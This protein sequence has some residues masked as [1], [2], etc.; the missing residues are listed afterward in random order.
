MDTAYHL[1]GDNMKIKELLSTEKKWTKGTYA[2]NAV[3]KACSPY[4]EEA[5]CF[6]LLGAVDKCYGT[7]TLYPST[8]DQVLS[9]LRNHIGNIAAFNDNASY[10]A[11]VKVLKELDI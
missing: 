3:G 7:D 6:C 4:S 8:K 11:V 9:K 5:V 1:E 2:R 10:F